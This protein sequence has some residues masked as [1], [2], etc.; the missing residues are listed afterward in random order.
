[1]ALIRSNTVAIGS[2]G[3]LSR[4]CATGRT[5]WDSTE[6]NSSAGVNAA[7]HLRCRGGPGRGADHQVRSVSQVETSLREA[8]DDTDLPRVSGSP[9]T[10][11]DKSNVLSHRHTMSAH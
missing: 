2:D 3:G 4:F 8:G 1:M 7:A 5:G 9:S 6:A 10:T 11:E